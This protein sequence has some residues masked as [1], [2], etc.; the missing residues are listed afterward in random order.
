MDGSPRPRLRGHVGLQ[1]GF[2][3]CRARSRSY[4]AQGCQEELCRSRARPGRG[5]SDGPGSTAASTQRPLAAAEGSHK[6]TL[7]RRWQ[8]PSCLRQRCAHWRRKSRTSA[9]ASIWTTGRRLPTRRKNWT[10]S[11][12]SGRS[13][14][15][16]RASQGTLVRRKYGAERR[17][18]S[19]SLEDGEASPPHRRSSEP[20]S[21]KV[22]PRQEDDPLRS[23]V[24]RNSTPKR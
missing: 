12:D 21:P 10:R 15:P 22:R 14:R 16:P 13:S 1:Q 5:K 23:S 6:A 8:W 20:S 9:K 3:P 2:R 24:G 4:G 19:A 11:M 17:T 18:P 7:G